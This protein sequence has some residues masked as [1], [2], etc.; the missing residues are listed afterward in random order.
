M[1]T[2]DFGSPSN[3]GAPTPSS[4][5]WGEA[6]VDPNNKRGRHSASEEMSSK[7]GCS[8]TN[9]DAPAQAIAPPNA[10]VSKLVKL[11][12]LI[13]L[14]LQNAVYTMLRRYRC[15]TR[16]RERESIL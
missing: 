9:G 14:C 3:A 16:E 4:S 13:V 2:R 15:E 7:H 5:S 1:H 8:T 6:G 12:L 11:S 10:G